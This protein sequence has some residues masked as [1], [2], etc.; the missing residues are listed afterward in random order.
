LENHDVVL[1]LM[2]LTS[3]IENSILDAEQIVA[4]PAP[5]VSPESEPVEP[6]AETVS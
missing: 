1:N 2:K 4:Q 6:V 3:D 5:A